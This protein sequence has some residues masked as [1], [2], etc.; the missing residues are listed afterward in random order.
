MA[1]RC[2]VDLPL[3]EG[4]SG[5]CWPPAAWPSRPEPASRWAP[6]PTSANG[7][8]GPSAP[9]PAASTARAASCSTPACCVLRKSACVTRPRAHRVAPP[10]QPPDLRAAYGDFPC[11]ALAD[12]IES[13]TLRALFVLGGNPL[14]TLPDS[15]RLRKAFAGLEIL[16]VCDIRTTETTAVAT[17][18][19]PVAGQLERA[20]LTSFLD[21]A[22]PFPFAQYGPPSVPAHPGRPPMWR[23][24]AGL[25]RRL[26][27]AGFADAEQQTDDSLLAAAAARSR[28]PWAEL[29]A[30]PSGDRPRR[31][32][33]PRLA[34]P[35]APAPRHARP[36]PAR[37]RDPARG[38]ATKVVD[39]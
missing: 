18:V 39:R 11:T 33:R 38:L 31:H 1:E 30:A 22:F 37:A 3:V 6:P 4:R 35:E 17:H 10:R 24:F 20:D 16:A 13:G 32:A 36:R 12:E 23:I 7:S 14:T 28:V 34:H 9:S 25:G 15:D 27:L 26:G 21:L 5:W 19:L 8:A 2:A 29:V